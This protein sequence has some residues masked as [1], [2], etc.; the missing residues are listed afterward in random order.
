VNGA[1]RRASLIV[2][3]LAVAL[4]L[5]GMLLL[6]GCSSLRL[7]YGNA[8][9]IVWWWLDGYVDFDRDQK[10]QAKAAVARWLAWHRQTQLPQYRQWLQQTELL[11][12]G[13]PSGE[14]LCTRLEAAEPLRAQALAPLAQPVADIARRLRPAQREHLERRFAEKNAE[15]ADKHMQRNLQARWD[16]AAERS[17]DYT[18]RFY[19]RLSREQKRWIAQRVQRS[20]WR[21]ENDLSERQLR[22]RDTLATLQALAAPGLPRDEARAIAT[23]W[24]ERLSAPVDRPHA[25]ARDTAR[26]Y[27]CDMAADFHR[28]QASAA[29]RRH[30]AEV[31]QGWQG[32]IDHFLLHPL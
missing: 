1:A 7:V 31:L 25:E 29:Q 21:P 27:L 2:R 17:I 24:L 9:T 19:G 12:H 10:P 22:Q 32:D 4:L 15:W 26:R 23:A 3:R 20:P 14:Q 13:E 16:A 8:E 30:L 18:E 28:Q 5:G 6:A 11:M